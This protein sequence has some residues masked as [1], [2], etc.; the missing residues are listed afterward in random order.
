MEP[1]R[2]SAPGSERLS[3]EQDETMGTQSH[4]LS[5]D[6]SINQLLIA[7]QTFS[8]PLPCGYLYVNSESNSMSPSKA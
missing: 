5:K 2:A 4:N 8:A 1:E 7:K 3:Q 6:L